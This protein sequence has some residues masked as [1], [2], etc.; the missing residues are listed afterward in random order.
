MH[1]VVVSVNQVVGGAWML[2]A[3]C[4]D[5]LGHRGG[6]HVDCVIA[7]VL[8]RSQQRH[9]IQRR[10]LQ[11]V[12]IPLVHAPHG[13]GVCLVAL[14]L[15]AFA[16]QVLNGPQIIL[17][18][19]GRCFGHPL[20]CGGRQARQGLA[21]LLRVLLYPHRMRVGEGLAPVGHGESRVDPAGSLKFFPRVVVLEAV[22]KQHALD[23]MALRVGGPRRWEIDVAEL[24]QRLRRQHNGESKTRKQ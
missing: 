3:L 21:R 19:L 8:A 1:R 18:S 20:R 15:A 6:A 2:R 12:G 4:E 24:A 7:I 14:D 17:L 13:F 22:Q 9:R 10:C 23:E 5:L 16:I 11:I